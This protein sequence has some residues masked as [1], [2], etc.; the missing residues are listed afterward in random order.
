MAN[1]LWLDRDVAEWL[2]RIA[3]EH[4]NGDVEKAM[5]TC[6][7]A[8]MKAEEKPDDCWAAITS[9]AA[10]RAPRRAR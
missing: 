2:H 5:N 1:P 8:L 9:L 4:F 7:N 10:S 6:L 3:D